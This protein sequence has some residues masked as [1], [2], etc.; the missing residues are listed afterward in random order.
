MN[1]NQIKNTAVT[2]TIIIVLSAVIMAV[3]FLFSSATLNIPLLKSYFKQGMIIFM[4]FIPIFL[5]MSFIYLISNKLWLGYLLT[6]LIFTTMGIV[7]K[8]KL[9]YRDEPFAFIDIKLIKESFKMAKTYDLHLSIKVIVMILGLITIGI[10]L[11]IFFQPKIEAKNVRIALILL[12]S[13]LSIFIFENYYFDSNVY[14]ELGDDGLMNRW[15]YSQSYQ[16]KGLVYPFIYSIQDVKAHPPEGYDE[17]KAKEDLSRN[18]YTDIPDNKKINIISIMLEAY[19]DFSQ[20]EDVDLN[21]DIYEEFHKIQEESVHGKLLTNIFAGGTE[22]TERAFLTGYHSQPKYFGK[23]NSF[24]WYLK[25]QGYRTKAM[26][27]F[28]GSF[29]NRRNINE[30]LGFDKFDHYDNKYN[31]FQDW[32]PIMDMDFFDFIIEGFENSK[33]DNMP[34]FN[35]SVTYQNHGPYSDEKHSDTQYLVKKDNYDDSNYNI[36]NNY[37]AGIYETDAAFKKLFDYFRDEE[38]PVLIVIFGDHNPWLGTGNSVYEMLDINLNLEDI[39]GFK[40][41]YQTPYIIW[42]NNG[43]KEAL[44]KDLTGES[45][46]VGPN[47]LMSEIFEHLD[48]KGDEYMQYITGM[49]E[50]FDVNHMLYF[51]ENGEFTSELSEESKKVWQEFKNIEYYYSNN[52]ER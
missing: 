28:T 43:T 8:L 38:E 51:K 50:K 12:L 10:L 26:H 39:E 7:N 40:N 27:P 24:V 45:R 47:F 9:T 48:W 3:T 22:N 1:K 5:L 35:F 18:N 11:K 31:Q 21:I 13:V 15:I 17:N 23:T 52:F 2:I 25:E 32:H 44:G 37:M 46:T 33:K 16:S 34:Y 30:Y 42:G 6:A 36:M 20:F 14:A 41:Y 49:K 4:N 29:Y 19:N